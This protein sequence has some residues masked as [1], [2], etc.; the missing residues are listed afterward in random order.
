MSNLSKEKIKIEDAKGIG[1]ADLSVVKTELK[2][3]FEKIYTTG[4]PFW[5]NSLDNH[6]FKT[7]RAV[8][9]KNNN[10]I[11]GIFVSEKLGIKHSTPED[12]LGILLS[13]VS[14]AKW[15]MLPIL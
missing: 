12:E 10:I 1:A 5:S 7:I 8:P 11:T 9:V 14:L 4:E 2:E 3:V 13:I 15:I 6:Y